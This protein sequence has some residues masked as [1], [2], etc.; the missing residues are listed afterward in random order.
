MELS[1]MYVLPGHH[2]SEVS[3]A[4]MAATVAL[5]VDF[6]CAGIWLGVNQQNA[7]AQRYYAKHGFHRV[8]TKTFTVGAE[9]HDDFVFE[10]VL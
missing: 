4:L 1:K 7:R 5:A 3:A 10:R 9:V 6:G 8:G 2:G